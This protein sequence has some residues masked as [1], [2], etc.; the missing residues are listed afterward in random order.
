MRML[1]NSNQM[2]EIAMHKAFLLL[3]T[4]L[5][6]AATGLSLVVLPALLLMLLFGIRQPAAETVLVARFAGGALLGLSI[7]AGVGSS[8]RPNRA[9]LGTIAGALVYDAAAATLLSF[10]GLS[11]G[12]VGIGLWPAVVFHSALAVWCLVCL[13]E[14]RRAI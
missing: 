14:M 2:A 10:A 12:F 6:E 9:Q 4:A 1:T 7:A 11:L 5:V 8:D 3:V 13:V